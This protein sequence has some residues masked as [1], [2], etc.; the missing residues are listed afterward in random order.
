MSGRRKR[1]GLLAPVT[2][3]VMDPA[4]PAGRCRSVAIERVPVGG[5]VG[6]WVGRGGGGGIGPLH[7]QLFWPPPSSAM[8]AVVHQ[9]QK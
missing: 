5:G 8:S 6:G 9:C 3:A 4:E 1:T 7:T 2:L